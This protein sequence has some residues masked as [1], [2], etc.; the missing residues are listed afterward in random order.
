MPKLQPG[1]HDGQKLLWRSELPRALELVQMGES[2]SGRQ[3]VEGA[4]LA[5][6]TLATLAALS[7]PERRPPE[8]RDL[9]PRELIHRPVEFDLLSEGLC[10]NLRTARRGAAAGRQNAFAGFAPLSHATT[11]F[12]EVLTALPRADVPQEI[13]GAISLGRLTALRKPNRRVKGIVTGDILRWL[14]AR[15]MA[16]QFSKRAEKAT[17]FQYSLHRLCHPRA[18]NADR[19]GRLGHSGLCGR[20]WCV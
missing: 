17:A 6:G 14:V 3:A 1:G 9:M 2:S 8:T 18:P 16:Q 4:E 19:S 15:T 7:D 20:H 11:A 5:P 13:L 10:K 12:V